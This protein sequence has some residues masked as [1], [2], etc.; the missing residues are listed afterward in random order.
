MLQFKQPW[1]MLEGL[2]VDVFRDQKEQE[3]TLSE[4]EKW[5]WLQTKKKTKKKQP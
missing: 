2:E 1:K 5:K 4:V 3:S